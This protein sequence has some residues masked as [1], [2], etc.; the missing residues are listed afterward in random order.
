MND[1]RAFQPAWQEMDLASPSTEE[2]VT[3]IEADVP[4]EP[5]ALQADATHLDLDLQ[6]YELPLAVTPFG[7]PDLSH[8]RDIQTTFVY[9]LFP[10]FHGPDVLPMGLRSSRFPSGGGGGGSA[11]FSK[12]ASLSMLEDEDT[13]VRSTLGSRTLSIMRQFVADGEKD[14]EKESGTGVSEL[15]VKESHQAKDT[16]PDLRH[17]TLNK[18]A[19]KALRKLMEDFEDQ[20]QC[21][22]EGC[23]DVT[24]DEGQEEDFPQEMAI[25]STALVQGDEEN[26][27]T[28]LS[29]EP[30][31]YLC[32]D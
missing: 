14:H 11:S 31:L 20:L 2:P 6:V 25:N 23:E 1:L 24:S 5:L 28:P 18:D 8:T 27:E 7:A 26:D 30:Q 3:Q 16:R 17:A 13:S 21:H 15:N 19:I 12:F 22:N 29:K 10:R 32:G 9:R 4:I